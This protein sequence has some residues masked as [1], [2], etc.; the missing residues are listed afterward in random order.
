MIGSRLKGAG[1][2]HE[3]RKEV[4][5]PGFPGQ[6]S[7]SVDFVRKNGSWACFYR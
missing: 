3:S 1:L 2:G 7:Q 4:N 5:R 6:V